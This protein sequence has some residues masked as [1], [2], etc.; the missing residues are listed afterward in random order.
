MRRILSGLLVAMCLL[1]G[2]QAQA[3]LL[4]DWTLDLSSL[5]GP[6]AIAHI[7]SIGM[8]GSVALV[9][10]VTGGTPQIGDTFTLSNTN[11]AANPI[12]FTAVSYINSSLTNVTPLLATGQG[13]LFLQSPQLT[14]F[15]TQVLGGGLYRY[16][17]NSPGAG[18]ISLDYTNA[19]NVT[20]QIATFDLLSANSGGQS[21]DTVDPA[22]G[23]V[24][25]TSSISGIMHVLLPGIIFDSLGE[26]LFTLGQAGVIEFGALSGGINYTFTDT[27]TQILANIS[28]NNNFTISAVPEPTTM[29]LLGS[30][31]L[32]LPFLRRRNKRS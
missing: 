1:I 31:I 6:A 7:N 20:T 27:G 11:N 15:I 23:L 32:G 18:L 29:L 17:Y 12:V 25:G 8:N 22:T 10:N 28:S 14:G 4:T 5:G 16:T 21:S 30:G 26:D 2:S 3:V 19:S 9:Q 24:E 13:S